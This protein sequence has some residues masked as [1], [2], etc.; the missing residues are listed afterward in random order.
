M[1]EDEARQALEIVNQA[2]AQTRRAISRSG[3]GYF[4]L[5]WGFVWL[6]GFLGSELLA[7]ALAGYLWLALDVFG[8]VSSVIV[9]LRLGRRVRSPEGRRSGLRSLALWLLLIVYGAL[10][11]WVAE[12][13][14][15]RAVVF[16]SLFVAFGYV[17]AGLS[18]SVPLFLTGLG[19]TVLTL[20][21][22]VFSPAYLGLSLA[23]VGG[24]GMI[25]VGLMMLRA[26][27]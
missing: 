10:L 11:Y 26:W 6:A 21:A 20:L 4:F 25:V 23:V 19:I 8:I 5:I 12:P 18:I 14:A 24:G 27:E 16:I 9:G 7:S 15:G 22:W 1:D 17:V 3:T 13:P 2:M